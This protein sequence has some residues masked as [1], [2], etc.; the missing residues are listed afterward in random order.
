MFTQIDRLMIRGY[1]KSYA[2]CLISLLTLYVVVDMFTNLDDFVHQNSSGLQVVLVR[3]V[4]YY[5]YR[6]PQFFDRLCEAIVLLA[7]MF[8]VALMQR[9]NEQ[10]PLLS[11]G[12]STQR[13]VAPVLLC[14]C[15]M[16][17]LTVINQEFIIPQIGYKIMLD[18]NDPDGDRDLLVRGGYE[19]NLIHVE[20][21]RAA[22]K[23]QTVKNFRC[24]IPESLAGNL[25]HIS[26]A[27]A[28]YNP[29][30]GEHPRGRWELTG[31]TPRDLDPIPEIL[32]VRDAGRYF[33]YTRTIDF[34]KLVRDPK[35]FTL[36]STYQLY[37]EL[38]R[39]ESTRLAAIAVLFHTRLTRPLL[40]MVLMVMGLSV[41]LRDQ[42]RNV[43]IS[44]GMCL[45]LCAVFFVAVHACKMLG[46]NEFITPALAAWLPV[47][48]F[49]PFAVAMFD[50][51]HT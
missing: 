41:I 24:T 2:I 40:G 28:R 1:F 20:G 44:A 15:F 22:R 16:L 39:P 51:V 37:Q 34:E 36:A 19:P 8:T 17:T 10:V 3:I 25:I 18:R 50:A 38:H 11:A 42:N 9:N 27:E 14:A 47:M 26:A 23:T 32:E 30:D 6:V 4:S 46:D 21:E 33:L 13:I 29:G 7:A 5:G 43:I 35:W 48:A 49:G 31:C 45:V 12:V